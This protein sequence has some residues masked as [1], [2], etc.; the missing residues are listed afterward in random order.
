MVAETR[1]TYHEVTFQVSAFKHITSRQPSRFFPASPPPPP[2]QT[3]RLPDQQQQPHP[4]PSSS[5]LLHPRTPS[6]PHRQRYPFTT[7]PFAPS[8][9]SKVHHTSRHTSLSPTTTTNNPHGS[10]TIIH[11]PAP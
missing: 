11:Q 7:T 1:G 3:A 4:R 8:S 6:G 2:R 10:V 9:L 5:P